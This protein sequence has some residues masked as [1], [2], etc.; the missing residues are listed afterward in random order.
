M[1]GLGYVELRRKEELH[2]GLVPSSPEAVVTKCQSSHISHGG[3]PI[4]TRTGETGVIG[5]R[6]SQPAKAILLGRVSS[7]DNSHDHSR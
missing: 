5:A 3:K 1:I 4:L 6:D 2:H 7:N